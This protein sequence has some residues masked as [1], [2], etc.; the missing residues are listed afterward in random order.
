MNAGQQNEGIALCA[1]KLEFEHPVT[2][3]K[4]SFQ[5]KPDNSIFQKF[6]FK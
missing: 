1:Y 5:I 4:L 2:K 3:R 6:D